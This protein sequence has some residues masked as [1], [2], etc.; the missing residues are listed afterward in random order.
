MSTTGL[1]YV[2][3]RKESTVCL[4]LYIS[5]LCSGL[6]FPNRTNQCTGDCEIILPHTKTATIYYIREYASI[7]S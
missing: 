6:F 1:A 7:H 3:H 5:F 2:G 4:D